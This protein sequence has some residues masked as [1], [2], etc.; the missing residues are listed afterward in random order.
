MYPVVSPR[1]GHTPHDKGNRSQFLCYNRLVLYLNAY[2]LIFDCLF[3]SS[4]CFPYPVLARMAKDNRVTFRRRHAY[5]TRS[6]RI[7][8]FKTPGGKV[9]VQYVTKAAKPVICGDFGTA[10]QGVSTSR[11]TQGSSWMSF[12]SAMHLPMLSLYF[13]DSPRATLPDE[14]D[15]SQQANC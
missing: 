7:R 4:C 1:N 3:Y 9:S 15:L 5:N 2:Y 8:K 14:V 11:G 6:N 13:A 10:L 12:K